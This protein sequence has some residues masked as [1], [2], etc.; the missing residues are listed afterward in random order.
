MEMEEGGKRRGARASS[1]KAYSFMSSMKS[2]VENMVGVLTWILIFSTYS[3]LLH[4]L[5]PT[6]V[7][8]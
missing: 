3:G 7:C 8:D 2:H 6:R 5:N 4:R 1:L